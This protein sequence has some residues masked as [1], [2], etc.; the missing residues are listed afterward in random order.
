MRRLASNIT[1][2]FIHDLAKL[3]HVPIS[4]GL[5]A[6]IAKGVGA[7]ASGGRGRIE[8][9]VRK[10]HPIHVIA[11]ARAQLYMHVAANRCVGSRSGESQ[12]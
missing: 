1:L 3:D 9:G 2:K 7:W 5:R 6:V 12:D 10:G 11:Y 8:V 4:N